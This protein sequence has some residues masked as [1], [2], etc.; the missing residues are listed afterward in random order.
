MSWFVKRGVVKYLLFIS[1]R[2]SPFYLD[3][4][5]IDIAHFCNFNKRTI[6]KSHWYKK[7]TSN[8]N[9][10]GSGTTWSFINPLDWW[11]VKTGIIFHPWI[12]K[13][14]SK[15]QNQIWILLFYN[16]SKG[17]FFEPVRGKYTCNIFRLLRHLHHYHHVSSHNRGSCEF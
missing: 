8:T 3:E 12:Y 11:G 6:Y 10:V 7:L 1:Y 17:Y 5:F 2:C 16:W 15:I 4:S 9:L 14:T 13:L